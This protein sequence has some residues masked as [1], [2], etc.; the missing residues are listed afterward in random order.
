MNIKPVYIVKTNDTIEWFPLYRK[1]N[2]LKCA[3]EKIKESK[4]VL[5][6]TGNIECDEQTGETR[7]VALDNGENQ[8]YHQVSSTLLLIEDGVVHVNETPITIETNDLSVNIRNNRK[9]KAVSCEKGDCPRI[10]LYIESASGSLLI[11]T[12][13]DDKEYG[14]RLIG[15][16]DLSCD[17]HT[18]VENIQ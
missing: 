9:I 12:V 14:L 8:L 18:V 16:T 15:Y 2:A 5:L 10:D 11:G 4:N 13:E 3:R 1:F 7:M 17:E 6:A